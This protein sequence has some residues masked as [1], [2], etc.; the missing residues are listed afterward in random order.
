MGSR[1]QEP[2]TDHHVGQRHLD[3]LVMLSDG[4]FAIAIT[5]SALEIQPPVAAAATSLWKAWSMPLLVYFLSFLVIGTIW[6]HHRRVVAHLRDIDGVGTGINLLLLSLVALMPVVTRY[7]I[8]VTHGT[9]VVIYVTAILVTFG[10][11]ALL[12]AYL[13]FVARLAPDVPRP[14]AVRWLLEIVIPALGALG[15][16]LYDAHPWITLAGMVLVLAALVGAA[17]MDGQV[18]S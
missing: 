12:W 8:E 14:R 11:T 10:C 4:V 18:P 16:V 7:V 13:A 9:G 15:V 3:R 5:L 1:V 2:L 17:R 6:F